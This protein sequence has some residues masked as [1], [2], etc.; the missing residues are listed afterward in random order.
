M[1]RAFLGEEEK[2]IERFVFKKNRKRGKMTFVLYMKWNKKK[3]RK[4]N[5]SPTEIV[6]NRFEIVFSEKSP[7]YKWKEKKKPY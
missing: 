7:Y 3:G 5:I 4:K 1:E 2:K 6:V